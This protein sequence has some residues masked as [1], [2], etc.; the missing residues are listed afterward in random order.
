MGDSLGGD[1]LGAK[2]LTLWEL[3][4]SRHAS[5]SEIARGLFGRGASGAGP[6]VQGRQSEPA[7][8][9]ACGGSR[10]NGSRGGGPD[11]GDGSPDLAGLG[12]SVKAAWAGWG[13]D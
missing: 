8:S 5:S 13:F 1:S 11:W 9:V 12:A 10:R 4:D 2:F 7:A 3:E 6:A